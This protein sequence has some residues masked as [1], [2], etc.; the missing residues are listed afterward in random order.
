MVNLS[1]EVIV[2][3]QVDTLISFCPNRVRFRR[4]R[5]FIVIFVFK[6]SIFFLL[7]SLLLYKMNLKLYVILETCLFLML[8]N[9]I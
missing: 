2:V 9:E 7:L 8:S 4:F 5:F 1:A 3:G 6:C